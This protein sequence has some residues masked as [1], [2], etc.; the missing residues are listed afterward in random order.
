MKL[1]LCQKPFLV[2]PPRRLAK[3]TLV[4]IPLFGVHYIIC[5]FFPD[6][7]NSTVLE[8][9]ILFELVLGSF[10]VILL[11]KNLRF[12][13]SQKRLLLLNWHRASERNCKFS[14]CEDFFFRHGC[15]QQNFME[16]KAIDYV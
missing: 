6:D 14:K 15:S 16:H 9:Q 3:S 7:A 8:I 12:L 13:P 4:L 2:L 11:L 1:T 10:Q 5:A